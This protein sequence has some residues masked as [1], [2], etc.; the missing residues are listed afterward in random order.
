LELLSG[1][2]EVSEALV[3]LANVPDRARAKPIAKR[4]I[5]ALP[6]TPFFKVYPTAA[7]YGLDVLYFAPSPE[8]FCRRLIANEAIA[9]ALDFL[10]TQRQADGRWPITWDPPGLAALSEWRGISS[11][12][13]LKTLKAYGRLKF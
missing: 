13:V 8:S 12:K 6:K 7:C 5:S 10:A 3:F 1:A 2:H 4:L 11:L 9:H